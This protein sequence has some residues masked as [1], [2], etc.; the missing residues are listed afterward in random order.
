M[1]KTILE[2]IDSPSRLHELSQHDLGRLAEEI[3]DELIARISMNGGHLASNLGVVELSMAVHLAFDSPTDKIVWDV[4]HQSYVHKL[5]TG[6]REKFATIRQYDG[7]SG[8]TDRD[9]S[10]HDAFGAGH[11]ST[12]VSAAVG[13]ALARDLAGES[14]HV[15][16]LIG[17]AALTGGMAI[18]ALNHAGHLGTKII[19]ILNDNG[20][21]ISPSVGALS[22]FLR[23]IELDARYE[24]AKKGARRTVTLLPS[25]DQ[26][27]ALSKRVKGNIKRALVPGA[28]WEKFGY[29]YIGPIDGHDVKGLVAALVRARDH[30]TKP[31]IV[32]VLT[33]KGRGYS[34]AEA[35]ATR[36]HGI[37]P[38]DA[39]PSNGPS[40]A[41]IFGQTVARLMRENS[42][43]VAITAAMLDGTGLSAVSREFPNRVF[44]VG[45]CEQHAVTLA[46]GLATRGFIPIVAI[47]STFLQRAY[48]QV[49]HDICIQN[50]PV[51][52]AL[53][54]AGIVGDDG[55]TH[56]GAFDISYLSTI[57]GMIVAAPKDEDELQ[58][59]L[60]TAV[61]CGR[62]MAIR[63][64][65][66]E[67][68]GT[69][70]S[71]EPR[72]LPIG[73]GELLRDGADIGILAIGSTIVAAL[74]AAQQL[75]EEG[76]DC[77]VANARFAKPLD[78]ELVLSMAAK[79]G[80]LVTVEENALAGGFGSAVLQLCQSSNL[81]G[82]RVECIGL[83]D[84]FVEQG[85]Q[86]QMR[87][88]FDLDSDGI[89]RRLRKSFPE[90]FIR[91]G[92]NSESVPGQTSGQS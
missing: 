32:H 20:M 11:A 18:E 42:R 72:E 5:L 50:L 27:W 2:Q 7:L 13:I 56:Q 34:A 88:T 24:K 30:E 37:P 58:H 39:T 15:V 52:F 90:L 26:A 38:G 12:S 89:V 55:K 14:Y 67:S 74:G 85:S 25:G 51:V 63:Y 45:I 87:A 44:D 40:Y 64:P 77:A 28:L 69:P 1:K 16:A 91:G 82:L 68:P 59:L 9:E 22:R 33:Q 17:D 76:V 43:I 21:A 35:D 81:V 62:P 6:R 65:R 66:G 75:A 36:F 70:L 48:D 46:G 10:P 83:P 57:P 86:Q 19:V 31:T 78:S 71:P 53:D 4:G 92:N 61:A 49:I 3:R 29:T 41:D 8:F 23:R 79:S 47:Y 60:I 84:V 80:R 54:R 73:K